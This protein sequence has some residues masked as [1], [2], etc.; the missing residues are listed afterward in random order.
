MKKNSM[1][2]YIVPYK[3]NNYKG[4]WW[5]GDLKNSYCLNEIAIIIHNL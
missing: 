4:G 5:S 3:K 2:N 1:R